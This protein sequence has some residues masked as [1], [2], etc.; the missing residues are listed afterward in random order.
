MHQHC[1]HLVICIVG[2]QHCLGRVFLCQLEQKLVA[3]FSPCLLDRLMGFFGSSM[4]V[5]PLDKKGNA[6]FLAFCHHHCSF[7][8]CFS[9]QTVVDMPNDHRGF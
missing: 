5:H 6:A 7:F 4:D 1:L 9:A 3:R 2:Y 8:I